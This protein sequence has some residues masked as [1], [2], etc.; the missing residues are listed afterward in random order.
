MFE[1][2]FMLEKVILFIAIILLL[3]ALFGGQFRIPGFELSR[4]ISNNRLRALYGCIGVI[5]V[6]ILHFGILQE[7]ADLPKNTNTGQTNSTLSQTEKD[8]SLVSLSDK[9]L[10]IVNKYLIVKNENF[11]KSDISNFLE[12]IIIYYDNSQNDQS[13][14]N[15]SPKSLQTINSYLQSKSKDITKEEKV[16]VIENAL[17]AFTTSETINNNNDISTIKWRKTASNLGGGINHVFHFICP[18]NG[19]IAGVKVYGTHT[20]T[21]HSM[22]CPAAVHAGMINTKKG[23]KITIRILQRQDNYNGTYQNGIQSDDYTNKKHNSFR[24]D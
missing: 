5:L 9:S 11:T 24:F 4:F 10:E 6:V 1:Q 2:D 15:I 17:I 13:L 22:I 16:K 23:G 12:N 21:T 18:P 19:N 3:A 20:Y 14:V 8:K 7:R